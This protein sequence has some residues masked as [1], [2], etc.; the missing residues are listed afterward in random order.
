[1]VKL[2]A[3]IPVTSKIVETVLSVMGFDV[4]NITNVFLKGGDVMVDLKDI[5]QYKAIIH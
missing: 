3:L 5:I 2:T 4:K 1:M